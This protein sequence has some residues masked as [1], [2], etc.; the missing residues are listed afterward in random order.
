MQELVNDSQES[1]CETTLKHLYQNFIFKDNASPDVLTQ[2][3]DTNNWQVKISVARHINTPSDTLEKLSNDSDDIRQVVAT[4]SSISSTTLEKLL[5]D[6]NKQVRAAALKSTKLP[7]S[8]LKELKEL[9]NPHIN[10]NTLIKLSNSKWVVI[11]ERVALHT[12]T[13]IKILKHLANDNHNAVPIAVAHNP[14][15]HYSQQLL[16]KLI[17]SKTP[18]IVLAVVSNP[19]TPIDV[20]KEIMSKEIR[21]DE[22]NLIWAAATKNLIQRSPEIAA[23]YFEE[24]SKNFNSPSFTRLL[25]LLNPYIPASLLI[26]NYMSSSWLERYA[27]A[28]NPNTPEYI[29]NYL[30]QD[31]NR[32][33][34]AVAKAN[35]NL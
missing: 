13:P 28:K 4:N 16:N 20:L 33:V 10:S 7:Q 14:D 23:K 25:V 17:T 8:L 9:Q 29:R 1:V 27:V 26:K 21:T 31:V 22:S 18:E 5:Q 32:V 30:A 34:R 35:L 24:F 3:A 2:L 19:N 6:V 11:R 12:E 15:I